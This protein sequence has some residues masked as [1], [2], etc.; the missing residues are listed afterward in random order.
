[1]AARRKRRCQGEG[2]SGEKASVV[3]K[4]VRGRQ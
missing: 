3:A 4:A 1:M 2:G